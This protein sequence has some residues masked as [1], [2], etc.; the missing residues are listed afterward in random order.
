[1]NYSAKYRVTRQTFALWFPQ[2]PFFSSSVI[3]TPAPRASRE[4][5]AL[6]RKKNTQKLKIDNVCG[7]RRA[8]II[9]KEHFV[10]EVQLSGSL[11][12]PRFARK[13]CLMQLGLCLWLETVFIL[14][15]GEL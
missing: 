13:V 3:S 14:L 9:I 1:M 10:A 12:I 6:N 2:L 7:R 5:K 15:C 4:L 11:L 8:G